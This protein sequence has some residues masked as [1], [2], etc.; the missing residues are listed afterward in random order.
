MRFTNAFT[1]ALCTPTR[2]QLLTGQYNFRNYDYFSY[3]ATSERTFANH[4]QAA[5]YTTAMAGKWQ[6]G[7]SFQTPHHFGFDEYLLWQLERPDYWTRYKNPVLTRN[8]EP[9]RRHDGKYGPDLF[10]EFVLDFIQRNRERPFAIFYADPLVHDPFQPPPGHPDYA[11]HDAS[12]VNDVKYFPAMMSYL[13]KHVG[14]LMTKLDTLGLRESTLVFFLGDNGTSTRITSTM[15][16]QPFQGDKATST[17]AG[18]HVAFIANWKGTVQAGQ[19]RN[20]LV[21]VG[22]LFPTI[23]DAGGNTVA[24]IKHDGMSLYPT[25]TK[26]QPSPR[27]WIFQDY[28]WERTAGPNTVRCGR[29]ARYVH[30]GRFKLYSDGRF[31]DYV[32]D[33]HEKTALSEATLTSEARAALQTLRDVLT[34]MDA[35]VKFADSRR[36]DTPL[37][38]QPAYTFCGTSRGGGAG[39][40]GAGTLA[41]PGGGRAGIP[42]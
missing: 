17:D 2:A 33:P 3:L 19:V 15:N 42:N 7:G 18:N 8:G 14:E 12:S 22:D 32:A 41:A 27:K 37:Q 29:P 9:T 34:R 36:P 38:V 25:L 40:R 30:D 35:E 23:L 13:D 20:D 28:Y 16:G 5:G 26:G 11:G 6:L 39:G 1:T 24:N 10:Q 21:D 4:L 31:V